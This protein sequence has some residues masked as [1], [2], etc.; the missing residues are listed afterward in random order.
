MGMV[1]IKSLTK[2]GMFKI[3]I[4]Q[5]RKHDWKNGR[6]E[7]KTRMKCTIKMVREG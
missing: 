6:N 4:Q 7:G 5:R 2:R 1:R 3:L